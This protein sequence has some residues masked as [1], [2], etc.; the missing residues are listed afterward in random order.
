M[1]R[2]AALLVGFF[3]TGLIHAQATASLT[4]SGTVLEFGSD[5]AATLPV[6]AQR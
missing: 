2:S 4:I 1:P 3:A 6:P 5:G